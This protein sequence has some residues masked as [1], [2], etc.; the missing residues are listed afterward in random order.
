MGRIPSRRGTRV[1]GGTDRRRGGDEPTLLFPTPRR[2]ARGDLSGIGMPGQRVR[3]LQNVA[4]AIADATIPLTDDD[5]GDRL[6][7]TM[8]PP[9]AVK[10]ALLAQSGIGPWTAEY[11]AL[12]AL[13]DADAWPA[14]DLALRRA[15]V[16]DP[17]T[18]IAPAT[19]LALSIPWR[20]WRAYAAVHFWLNASSA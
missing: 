19:L 16:P 17:S 3:T 20:P 2:L 6:S 5:A 10:E 4:R 9:A 14:T 18:K 8:T 11:I 7:T 13:R 15:L 12:R 1:R